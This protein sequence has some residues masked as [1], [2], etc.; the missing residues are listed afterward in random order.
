MMSEN[1]PT[2]LLGTF[3]LLLII[4]ALSTWELRRTAHQWTETASAAGLTY[5]RFQLSG[6]YK[7]RKMIIPLDGG[8]SESLASAV[9]VDLKLPAP[10]EFVI[11]RQPGILKAGGYAVQKSRPSDF[12]DRVLAVLGSQPEL[13]NTRLLSI[14]RVE[15]RDSKLTCKFEG[16]LRKSLPNALDFAQKI[17]ETVENTPL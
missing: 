6:M 2:I 15:L 17:A 10:A 12:G 5:E 16:I 8:E 9:V 14:Q 3:L 7:G 4:F 13:A 11:A 1:L